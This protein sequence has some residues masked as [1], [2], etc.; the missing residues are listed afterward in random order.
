MRNSSTKTPWHLRFAPGAI[1]RP[2]GRLAFKAGSLASAIIQPV[3]QRL[4]QWNWRKKTALVT[5]LAITAAGTFAYH[6][7]AHAAAVLAWPATFKGDF[8]V[9][10]FIS[11]GV[12]QAVNAAITTKVK[13]TANANTEDWL[14]DRREH[15]LTFK[16]NDAWR[17]DG[18]NYTR[19]V[20]AVATADECPSH[21]TSGTDSYLL[22]LGYSSDALTK[23]E[24]LYQEVHHN[25]NLS[26]AAITY[27][28]EELVDGEWERLRYSQGNRSGSLSDYFLYVTYGGYIPKPTDAEL[29][30]RLDDF[31]SN[32]NDMAP[33]NNWV[34][35]E[36]G[37]LRV[38]VEIR[39]TKETFVC[40]KAVKL[41]S[42]FSFNRVSGDTTAGPDELET[43]GQRSKYAT[44]ISYIAREAGYSGS[45]VTLVPENEKPFIDY[46]EPK[47]Y[48]NDYFMPFDLTKIK[49]DNFKFISDPVWT[50][51]A[52][53]YFKH[54]K[55]RWCLTHNKKRGP[56]RGPRGCR[57]TTKH[58]YPVYQ[59][60]SVV[61]P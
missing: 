50:G 3:R 38:G 40:N 7:R 26:G 19:T 51:T 48:E 49:W 42:K 30:K 10:L 34:P 29:Q 12:S 54:K 45:I 20:H 59:N 44:S 15:H 9:K 56:G 16:E 43:P 14:Y 55:I 17:S 28:V 21:D 1:L 37:P 35:S 52:T 32:W 31:R 23:S 47:S 8:L 5:A 25:A 53:R 22:E 57:T 2:I 39:S 58:E 27:D 18:E 4:N 6:Q 36:M 41:W 61:K 24:V 11:I 33:T 46:P 13:K 60:E